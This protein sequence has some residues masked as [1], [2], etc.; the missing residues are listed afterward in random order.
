MKLLTAD[1]AKVF[2]L[3]LGDPETDAPPKLT[4]YK[5]P[6][7]ITA[8]QRFIALEAFLIDYIKGNG[9]TDVLI[10]ENIIPGI[11]SF[12]AVVMLAGYTLIAGIA[13]AKCGCNVSTISIQKWRSELGLP[14]QGPKNVLSHP[15]YAH[16]AKLKGGLKIAKR[17]WVK[18][19][20]LKLARKHGLD[21]KDDNEAD[22]ACIYIWKRERLRAK[23]EE[24]RYDLFADTDL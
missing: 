1:P 21:P 22:A 3:A 20:A 24:R 8:T 10:E 14:T 6:E 13:A 7:K 12:H 4:S 18:D 17:Q 2:G 11:T 19:A 5:L 15:D 9:V 16:L 23:V